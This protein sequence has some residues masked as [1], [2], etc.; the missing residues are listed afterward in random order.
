M[1]TNAL[2]TPNEYRHPPP[3]V[4]ALLFATTWVL[5]MMAV[6]LYSG[7]AVGAALGQ[8]L[9]SAVAL[10]VLASVLRARRE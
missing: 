9:L 2:P 1:D 6:L 10:G 3:L 5:G 4:W 7:A 8:A